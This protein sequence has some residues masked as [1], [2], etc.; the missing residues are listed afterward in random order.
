[1][2]LVTIAAISKTQ[3]D[4]YRRYDGDID[5]VYRAR[6]Q[7][8]EASSEAWPLIDQ[9]RQRLFLV[10]SGQASPEFQSRLELDLCASIPQE[11]VRAEL[12]LMVEADLQRT[13]GVSIG[14]T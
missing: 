3:L 13:A 1:V 6:D 8:A 11:S 2:A 4:L 9:L 10:L 7:A 12:R 14:A 5:G